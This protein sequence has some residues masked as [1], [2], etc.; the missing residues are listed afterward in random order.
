MGRVPL[1]TPLDC[2]I[3]LAEPSDAGLISAMSARL[4]E[5][6]LPQSWTTWRVGKYIR[7]KNSIVLT[8]YVEDMLSG[9]AIMHFKDREAHLNLLAVEPACRRNGIGR[10]LLCW[11]E[12]SAVVAGTFLI[13]LEV[14]ADN[15][16]A[17]EF[18]SDLGY[19]ETGIIPRYYDDRFDAALLARDLSV[20]SGGSNF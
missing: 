20:G 13:S 2:K 1:E 11:L 4:V 18:Y 8:A 16:D 12:E 7:N 19:L 14:R 6:G 17:R 9:F 15:L 5:E 10:K 3:A